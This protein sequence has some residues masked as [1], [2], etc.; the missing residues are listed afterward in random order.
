[1]YDDAKRYRASAKERAHR[2]ATGDPHQKVDASDWTPPEPLET[3]AKTGMRPVSPRQYKRGGKVHGEAAKQNAGRKMRKAGG[4][5]LVNDFI[6]R[7]DKEANEDRAGTKHIGGMKRGGRAH[8][9]D[10]GVSAQEAAA[11]VPTSRMAFSGGESRLSKA[12]GLK[13]GG[14]AE[15]GDAAQ[16]RKLIKSMVKASDLKKKA[17]GSVSDGTLEGTRPTGGRMARKRGGSAGKGKMN[18]NIVIA[19][20]GQGSDQASAMPPG[21][22]PPMMPPPRM[23]PPPAAAPPSIPPGMMLGAG[24]GAPPPMPQGGPPM[25]PRKRGGRTYPDMEA[26]SGSGLGRLEKVKDYGRKGSDPAHY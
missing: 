20:Q 6:N 5:A 4:R 8:K 12:A 23:A 22:P 10:G 7:D 3:E 15:H 26:G 25:M 17:G 1:M 9:A 24:A 2:M 11:A 18:V 13:R 19:P 14:K 16:D 21:A